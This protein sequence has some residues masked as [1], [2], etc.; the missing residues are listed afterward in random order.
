[1]SI[2]LG[3]IGMEM[4][5]SQ[6]FIYDTFYELVHKKIDRPKNWE[7]PY[8]LLL[9]LFWLEIDTLPLIS[10]SITHSILSVAIFHEII[11]KK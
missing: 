4:R 7:I 1:M 9:L 8:L 10:I 6:N 3:E 11:N 5:E 2:F